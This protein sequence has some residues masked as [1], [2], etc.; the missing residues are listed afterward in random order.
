MTI[1]CSLA[2][3]SGDVSDRNPSSDGR[4]D[5]KKS[6]VDIVSDLEPMLRF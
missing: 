5:V 6:D 1:A 3:T 2:M 4:I